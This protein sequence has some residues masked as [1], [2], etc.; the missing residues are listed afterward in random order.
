MKVQAYIGL[1]PYCPRRLTLSVH[2][3]VAQLCRTAGFVIT[4]RVRIVSALPSCRSSDASDAKSEAK[5]DCADL[6][7]AVG[8]LTTVVAMHWS[9]L[10]TFRIANPRSSSLV[11]ARGCYRVG[12]TRRWTQVSTFYSTF[13]VY[14]ATEWK[15]ASLF[16]CSV[17]L[18]DVVVVGPVQQSFLQ[19][20]SWQLKIDSFNFFV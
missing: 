17:S 16:H 5:A 15:A 6:V 7:T 14:L 10:V 2:W 3:L 12:V 11:V 1:G 19:C 20:F 4:D 18:S 9:R 13:C 8:S